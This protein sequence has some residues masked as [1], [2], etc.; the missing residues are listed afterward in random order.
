VIK[1]EKTSRRKI[2]WAPWRIR[3][4]LDEKEDGCLFCNK[5]QSNDDVNNHVIARSDHSFALLN[6][7]PYNSGHIMV[8][9]YRHTA[10][11]ENLP[12][13][14]V[15]DL[16]LLVQRSIK[17]LKET[18][19]PEGFNVGLNLGR[20]AG[21]GVVD[22]LHIHIVPRWQGDTNFMPVIADTDVIPQSLDAACHL[23]R[24]AME[25]RSS[26]A[27]DETTNFTPR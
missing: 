14:E 5:I 11:L 15:S 20:S 4:I 27:T 21:A 17:A 22:H 8:A 25:A 6:I 10:E 16:M 13:E 7:F 9:P 23:L 18:M 2:L 19:E 26:L 3:Y 24:E 12:A 1:R